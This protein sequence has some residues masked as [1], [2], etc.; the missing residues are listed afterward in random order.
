MA[1]RGGY[2][3]SRDGGRRGR[4]ATPTEPP[5]KAYVGNLPNGIVQG[6]INKI[7]QD[8]Q[9]KNV[10]L[11]M[12]R[13]TDKFKGFCYV[14]FETKTDLE[15]ALALD[16]VMN[17]EGHIIKVD[18]AEEKRN[19]RGGG[20]DRRGNRGGT[21]GFRGN[22]R[23]GGGG[24]GGDDFG[25][26]NFDRRGPRG[27]GFN[28]RDQRSGNRGNYG[29]FGNDDGG[30]DWNRGA[31]GR[32]GGGAGGGSGG[33]Y[34]SGGGGGG[35]GGGGPRPRPEQRD[36]RGPSESGGFSEELP[37]SNPDTT[38]R[39]KLKLK[40]RTNPEPVNTLAE[41]SQ[42]SAIFGGAKPREEKIEK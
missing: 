13:N 38:G 25:S 3:D 5:F 42:A 14:E 8:L 40:P 9:V 10:R 4:K 26:E 27:G 37:P 18:I 19:D 1:G 35:G 33:G 6:D 32:S 34:G 30:R 23:G 31:G 17:V 28:D 39:P 7:F 11:V 41:T 36:R 12:D 24:Y 15:H 29:N 20:F 16:G 21:G 22:N 2:E